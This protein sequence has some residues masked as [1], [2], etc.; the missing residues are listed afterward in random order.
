MVIANRIAAALRSPMAHQ[1]RVTPTL[2]RALASPTLP[3][4]IGVA[5]DPETPYRRRRGDVFPAMVLGEFDRALAIGEAQ[6]IG[7][8][9]RVAC[10]R[11]RHQRLHFPAVPGLEFENPPGW[12][13][14][15]ADCIADGEG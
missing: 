9:E 5:L 6:P 15:K 7:R 12:R 3:E 2:I 11:P 14:T 4:I 10:G 8:G 13:P 1:L